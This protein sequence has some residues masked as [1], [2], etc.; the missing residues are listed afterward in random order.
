[1]LM[2]TD[3]FHEFD[4]LTERMLGT[5]T[6]PATMPMDA[7]REGDRFIVEMDLPGV[8]PESIELDVERN[9]LTVHADRH[10]SAPK[11]VEMTIAERAVGRF[12]RQ[13]FLSES[14]DADAIEASYQGG[15]LRLVIPISEHPGAHR[16]AVTGK[17]TRRRIG[18]H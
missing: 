17:D 2:R 15:V 1:M 10:A 7:F 6:R 4:R 16:I 9:V 5:A 13:L 12:S 18:G 11:D 8:S 3:R 14:L